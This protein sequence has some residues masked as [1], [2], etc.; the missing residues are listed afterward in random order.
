[1]RRF[2]SNYFLHGLA[3]IGVRAVLGVG[4]ERGSPF[5][6]Q[7]SLHVPNLTLDDL[8]D[9]FAGEK[10][11]LSALLQRYRE[12][13][14]RLEAKGLS[15][16]QG[17]P[18]RSDLHLTE[19]VGHF[20]LYAW[21][22]QAVGRLCIVS[23]E[24]PTGNPDEMVLPEFHWASGKVDLCI[25]CKGKKGI[26]EVK[27]FVDKSDLEKSLEQAAT[28]ASS[29]ELSEVT[30]AVFVPTKDQEIL[31]TLSTRQEIEGVLVQVEAIGW[32]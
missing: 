15:P 6:I 14:Q 1:M 21:L 23:P 25:I 13:L 12:Y 8:A 11:N 24:F 22:R 3:L 9:V 10:L 27:S 18:R 29:L 2:H 19:A 28:Y 30:L 16:W 32:G 5:N 26:I 7:R 20:H 17:Q 31:D 4:S